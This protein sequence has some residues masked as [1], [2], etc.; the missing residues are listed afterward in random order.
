VI[1]WAAFLAKLFQFCIEKVASRK[2]ELA[3]DLDLKKQAAWTFFQLHRSLAT[4][5][6][7]C[8]I[9]V[10]VARPVADGA[11]SRLFSTR[12]HEL[13]LKVDDA[14]EQFLSLLPR[15]RLVLQCYDPNLALLVGK[16]ASSKGQ[17]L[18]VTS[19]SDAFSETRFSV[20]L[21]DSRAGKRGGI[22]C[23]LPSDQLMLTDWDAIYSRHAAQS[24]PEEIAR[25][26]VNEEWPKDCLKRLF[27]GNVT[28]GTVV[29]DDVE[30]LR[31]LLAFA[32]PQIGALRCA[33]R[34]VE[35]FIAKNFSIEDLLY[36]Q[37]R[38][39]N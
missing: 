38:V 1:T 29:P 24:D 17:F 26:A 27:A 23:S 4:L 11:K 16:A 13:A 8:S 33:L 34:A 31:V 9:F 3:L 25:F 6:E 36:V 21:P 35:G 32:E 20:E 30:G 39:E 28:E 12:L 22:S 14:S 10:N 18:F 19:V 2:M 15:L 37:D 5:D 7:A